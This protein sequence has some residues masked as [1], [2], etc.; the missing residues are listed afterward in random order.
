MEIHVWGYVGIEKGASRTRDIPVPPVEKLAC[1]GFSFWR[2]I[3]FEKVDDK[4][5]ELLVVKSIVVAH[6]VGGIIE[7]EVKLG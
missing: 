3:V 7:G 4:L 1:G 2:L 6:P 5:V